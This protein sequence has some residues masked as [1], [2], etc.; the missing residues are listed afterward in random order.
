MV[1]EPNRRFLTPIGDDAA[2][3]AALADLAADA[4]TRAVIGAAN[5]SKAEAEYDEATM[6]ATY[7]RIYAG[8]MGKVKFP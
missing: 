7:A 6:V 3:A 5:R 1:A 4:Q 2:L 8:A